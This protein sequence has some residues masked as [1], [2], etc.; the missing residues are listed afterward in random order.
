MPSRGCGAARRQRHCRAR[1]RLPSDR[2]ECPG[3]SQAKGGARLRHWRR[4][5]PHHGGLRRINGTLAARALRARGSHL[6]GGGRALPL[7][8]ARARCGARRHRNVGLCPVPARARGGIRAART[9]ARGD[10]RDRPPSCVGQAVGAVDGGA[11]AGDAR[12]DLGEARR[13]GAV[14]DRGGGARGRRRCLHRRARSDRRSAPCR[15]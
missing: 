9:R 13:G 8:R 1:S 11:P 7:P 12:G 3:R 14:V 4:G 15:S 2:T 10:A 6:D 5:L